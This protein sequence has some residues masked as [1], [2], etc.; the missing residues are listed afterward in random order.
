MAGLSHL[1]QIEEAVLSYQLNVVTHAVS[2]VSYDG[3]Y[4][5]RASFT[6]D[7][8]SLIM[9]HRAGGVFNIGILDLIPVI[10]R[11][12][13]N[14]GVDNESPSVAPNGSMILYGTLYSGRSVLGMVSSDGKVQLRL[15]ARDGDVQDPAWSPFL[16]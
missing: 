11:E 10:F 4:N 5:A 7:G 12:L 6:E 15:P 14:S 8:K 2:R 3:D 16:S 9:L 1:P 13:T